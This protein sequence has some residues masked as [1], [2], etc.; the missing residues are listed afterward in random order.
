M[1]EKVRREACKVGKTW[2]IEIDIGGEIVCVV[3]SEVVEVFSEQT[4]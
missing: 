3:P 4:E 2:M 1:I